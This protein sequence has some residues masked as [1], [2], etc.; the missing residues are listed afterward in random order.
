MKE[1]WKDIKGYEGLYQVSNLGRVKRL[2]GKYI[3]TERILKP[4]KHT[5]GYLRVKLCK[6]NV[7]FNKKI[8]RL[9]AEAFIPN[10]ENKPQVNHIDEDKTNNIIS[11]LEWM[12][13]KEN[14]NHGTHNE[15]VSKT[16]GIPIIAINC[17]TGES[18]EFH[19]ITECARQLG[20]Q[21][22]HISAVL[23]G[24]YKQ[25]GGYTFKYK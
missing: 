17:I 1:L 3:S 8:H 19:G 18:K 22:Q 5:T 6:N 9:V 25:T 20:L 10:P 24:R 2:K 21:H 12:T 23:K 16:M 13:A 11:N 7:R 15:R 14:I 4:T